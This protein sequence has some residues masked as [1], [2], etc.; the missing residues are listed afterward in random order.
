MPRL[1]HR[2]EQ[3]EN[4]FYVIGVVVVVML[5]AGFLRLS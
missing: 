2:P 1:D 5:A 4:M 3:E